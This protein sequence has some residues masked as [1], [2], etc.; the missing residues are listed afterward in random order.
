MSP[1]PALVRSVR[2]FWHWQWLKLM[3]GLA[4]A[5]A[6][7]H[8]RRP[9]GA[10]TALPPLPA[11][12][13][14]PGM[15]ALIVGR[16]CPWA[17]RAW[18]LWTLRG[19]GD[20]LL[21]QRVEPDPEAGR[22]RFPEPFLGCSTLADLYR[23]S[24][25]NRQARATV[26]LVVHLT[27][28]RILVNESARVIELLNRWPAQASAPDLEPAASAEAIGHWRARFQEAVNDGVYRCGFA[29]TQ[30]AYD[31]DQAALF[32]ALE[33][34]E[35]ALQRQEKAG[36]RWLCSAEVPTLADVVL[37]PTLIRW[38]MVYVPL[39]G[40]SQRPLWLLPALWRWRARFFALPG[41]AATCF[42]DQWRQDYFAALFP[43]HPSGLIPAGPDL[44]TL[45]GSI[46]P[47]QP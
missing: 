41:V 8:Y 7:G 20:T 38:E 16:S 14:E 12:A 3:G 4:P 23:R 15:Y 19:L 18:L 9:E 45:V 44:A 47:T 25:G 40:C 1:P 24:G 30:Q 34:A 31:G 27:S 11:D 22:W 37:F 35:Q 17:H 2:A 29:R 13:Q 33:E 36:H 26:P 5:D 32:A 46:P 39:F 6:E 10:F 28:G 42:A 43:L 21:L